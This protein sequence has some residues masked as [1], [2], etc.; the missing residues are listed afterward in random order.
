MQ[1]LFDII[2]N[3]QIVG[4][5]D[6]VKPLGTGLINDTYKVV[7]KGTED[8]NYVLQRINHA[9]FQDVEMLQDNIDAVTSHIR[10]KLEEEGED[11]I[12]RKV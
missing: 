10:H 6:E 2:E 5:I 7:T 3:F 8:P 4:V 12:E 1:K 11:D 9:I